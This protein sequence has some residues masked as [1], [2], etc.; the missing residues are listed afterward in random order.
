VRKPRRNYSGAN[1]R[2]PKEHN[3]EQKISDWAEKNDIRA[4]C[5]AGCKKNYRTADQLFTHRTL[6]AAAKAEGMIMICAYTD[7]SIAFD[8]IS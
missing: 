4:A 8:S 2:Q 6:I 7:Y 1:A 5:Q 3:F